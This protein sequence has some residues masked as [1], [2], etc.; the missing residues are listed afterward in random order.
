MDRKTILLIILVVVAIG[1]FVAFNKF[2]VRDNSGNQAVTQNEKQNNTTGYIS[3]TDVPVNQL[4]ENFPVDIP[5][6]KGT[7][8]V[9]NYNS[10]H[11]DG[12]VEAT[13]EFRT[14]SS[15]D[16]VKKTYSDYM[17]QAGYSID[18]IIEGDSLKALQ[19]NNGSSYMF[20]SYLMKTQPQEN[21]ITISYSEINK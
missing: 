4:P 6:E 2:F 5:L 14:S 21:F 20:V 3:K 12:T 11:N 1:V 19:G 15:W 13:R 16:E 18:S 7:K 17:E 10:V 8:V 9:Q